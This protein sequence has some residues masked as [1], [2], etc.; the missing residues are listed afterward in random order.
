MN[1]QLRKGIVDVS[2]R[3]RQPSDT[4]LGIGKKRMPVAARFAASLLVIGLMLPTAPCVAAVPNP[5]EAAIAA[6]LAAGVDITLIIQNAVAAGIPVDRAVEV[7][8]TAGANPGAVVNAA[9]GANFAAADVT[10]GAANAVQQMG[11]S[12][13][14][15]QTQL[16][17]IVQAATLAGAPPAQV[18]SGL[19]GAGFSATAIANANTNAASLPPP[20]FGYTAPPA[21]PTPP[22]GVIVAGAGGG[23]GG[24]AIGGSGVGAPSTPASGTKPA[25]PTRP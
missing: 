4:K 13:A 5:N 8:V 9:I 3:M 17:T 20:V 21:P 7:L 6:D 10:R 16:A 15:A 22:T 11:L 18:N 14:A 23:G 25:S 24:G 1:E 19:S 2:H 12:E